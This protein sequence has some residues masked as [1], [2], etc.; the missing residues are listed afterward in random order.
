MRWLQQAAPAS[1]DRGLHSTKEARL[2]HASVPQSPP[3]PHESSS[4]S[5]AGGCG[6]QPPSVLL[7]GLWS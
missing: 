2:T 1:Q 7:S 5:G 4:S 3:Q 6:Q